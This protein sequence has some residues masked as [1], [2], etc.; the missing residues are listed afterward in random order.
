MEY[1]KV[2]VTAGICTKKGFLAI[3]LLIGLGICAFLCS[4]ITTYQWY[5]ISWQLQTHKRLHVIHILEDL[6][7][8]IRAKPAHYQLLFPYQ[9][10]GVTITITQE[11][12]YPAA[13]QCYL[14]YLHAQWNMPTQ[15]SRSSILV[16]VT[17]VLSHE[18]D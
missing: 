11:I 4:I 9:Q 18:T 15:K 10:H 1:S 6:I 14:L 5:S 13:Q 16:P 2:N 8:Q 3:E 7:Q 12:N 17:L